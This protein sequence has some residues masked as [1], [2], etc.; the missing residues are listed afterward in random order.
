[1]SFTEALLPHAA[2]INS[3]LTRE[4]QERQGRR[5]QQLRLPD[6]S[7]CCP[8]KPIPTALPPVPAN[9]APLTYPQYM[10]ARCQFKI[11]GNGQPGVVLSASINCVYPVA[12]QPNTINIDPG[13]LEIYSST[14]DN[15][16]VGKDFPLITLTVGEH[17]FCFAALLCFPAFIEA[18]NFILTG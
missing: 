2:Q 12:A 3:K 6:G 5:L 18:Q 15:L 4:A 13:G 9:D 8:T 1:M 10:N 7:L 17:F 16:A 11:A 14:F